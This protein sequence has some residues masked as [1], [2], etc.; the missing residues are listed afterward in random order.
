MSGDGLLGS[1][2]EALVSV[3]QRTNHGCS[4]SLFGLLL[5]CFCL[6]RL[7]QLLLVQGELDGVSSRLRPQVVHPRLQAL[8]GQGKFNESSSKWFLNSI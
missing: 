4:V 1:T 2:H 3:L 6:L 8:R 7:L 5:G